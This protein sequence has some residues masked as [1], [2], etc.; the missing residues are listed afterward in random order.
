MPES[1]LREPELDQVSAVVRMPP[2]A[3]RVPELFQVSVVAQLWTRISLP[4][5][6]AEMVPALEPLL[7]K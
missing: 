7:P 3:R 4:A 2:L 5:V 6:F 1:S